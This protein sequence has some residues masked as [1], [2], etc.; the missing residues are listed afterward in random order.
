MKTYVAISAALLTGMAI[1]GFAMQGLQAQ[2]KPPAYAVAEFEITDPAVFKEFSD[3][4]QRGVAAAGGRFI[5]R[6]GKTM[7]IAG[8]P[9]KI[10]A[11]VAWDN[12]DQAQAYYNSDTFKSI[13]GPR[14]KGSKF[15]AFLVEATP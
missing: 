14:D 11:V 4:N 15:R 8:A 10:I 13:A 7:P 12:F 5:V 3:G 2:A 9:P 1:G 6:R